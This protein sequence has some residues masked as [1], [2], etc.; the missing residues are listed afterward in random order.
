VVLMTAPDEVG[1]NLNDLKTGTPE[2]RV[3]AL[4]CLA[5]ADLQDADRAQVAATLEPLLLDSALHPYLN[6]DLVL[7]LYLRCAG[8]N[9]VPAMIRLV[10]NP[11]PQSWPPKNTGSVI[12]TLGKLRDR[13]A[14]PALAQKL[15]DPLLHDQAI[16]ALKLM[17]PI[18]ASSV[19]EYLFDDDPATRLRAS[20]LLDAYGTRPW[21]IAA[22][23]LRRLKSNQPDAQR[24]AA[25][26]CAENP[27][28]DETQKAEGAVQLAKLLD[29]LSP[30]VDALALRALKL[31]AT[32]DCL[33][34]L[35][36]FA[37]RQEKAAASPEAAACKPVLIDVLAQFP[38]ETAAEAIALQLKDP[39]QRDKAVQAL[40]KLGP[41]ATG[42]VLPYLDHPDSAV[43]KEARSLARLLNISADRQLDQTLADVADSKRPRCRIALQSLARLRPDD[44]NRAKVARALNGPLLDA[45]PAI[46]DE[47]LNAVQVWVS[48]ENIDALVK[49]FGNLPGGGRARDGRAIEAVTKLLIALGPEVEAKVIPLLSSPDGVVRSQA[50]RIL[51]DVGTLKSVEPLQQAGRLYGLDVNFFSLTQFA[52][53]RITARK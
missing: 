22:E 47:A 16:Y 26:W 14:I 36:E 40:L 50:C 32:R 3:H 39:A 31:W 34:Q 41:V 7:R 9:N 8:H 1:Q 27:P 17:G 15:P 52:I 2:L 23:A 48:K 18:A 24:G 12:E 42:A 51:G 6:R 4:A 28:E 10:A 35:T 19:L 49:N 11:P 43:Q 45:D 13:R 25:A 38:D 33:P 37:R 21:T 44:A 53:Q 5:D 30:K 20:E 29:D 46:R